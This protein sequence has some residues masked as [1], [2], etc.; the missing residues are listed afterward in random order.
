MPRLL[1]TVLL[2]GFVGLMSGCG[3]RE[4]G[5][6]GNAQPASP[7]AGEADDKQVAEA[8]AQL[9]VVTKLDKNG[10][11]IVADFSQNPVRDA[12]LEPVKRLTQ[13]RSLKLSGSPIT[14]AGL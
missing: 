3:G 5:T 10:R 8:L 2:L 11:I 6:P 1:T 14:D 12:D 9:K 13:L 7:T 4:A